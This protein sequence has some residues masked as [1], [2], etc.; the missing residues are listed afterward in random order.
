MGRYFSYRMHPLSVAE[1]LRTNLLD[2]EIS[3]PTEI[4]DLGARAENFV[5]TQ[6]L[7]AVQY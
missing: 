2:T 4:D 7:K 6:L 1:C 3:D 5:A